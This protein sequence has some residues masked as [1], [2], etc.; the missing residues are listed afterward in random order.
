MGNSRFA[1]MI[2]ACCGFCQP[3]VGQYSK[4]PVR[5]ALERDAGASPQTRADPVTAP[6]VT[7][8]LL[9]A[10]GAPE[11]LPENA[12]VVEADPIVAAVRQQLASMS[13]PAPAQRDDYAALRVFYAARTQ[14]I[15]L[16]QG[17]LTARAQQAILEIGQAENWG[18]Q[19]SAFELPSSVAP[20]SPVEALAE[21]EIKLGVAILKYARQ[22]RGG[23]L[24][25]TTVSR[26][27]DQEPRL[28]DPASLLRAIA[29]VDDIAGYLRGLH[30]RH[31]QFSRLR[32]ALLA[33]RAAPPEPGTATNVRRLI[34]NMERWRWLP[35]D[36]GDF[37]VWDSIPEQMTRVVDRQKVTLSEK[38]VVGKPST[39]TPIFSADMQFIIFHPSWGVPA[40]MKTQELWPQLRNSGGGWFS[41]KPMAS[42]VLAGH[43]LNASRAGQPVNPDAVDWSKVDIREFDFVQPPGP[44][45]VLGIVKFR[46]P[47][48]HDV[49]MH[50]TPER[51]LFNGGVRAFSHGCMR[52]QNP[53]RLAEVL[54]AHDKGW[55]PSEVQGYV[56]RGG[57]I[58]LTTPIPVHVTYFTAI[59]DAAGNVQTFAD[60]YGLDSR[61]TSALEGATV[62]LG[63]GSKTAIAKTPRAAAPSSPRAAKNGKPPQ[64][65][66]PLTAIF[67]N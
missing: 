24:E 14:P 46:F 31:E 43:G 10:P 65:T 8:A 62:S 34:A 64:Q 39:P 1:V 25:P 26:K 61:L 56:R 60:I 17:A 9:P 42:T 29:N 40:G 54:L 58:T 50:D 57:E 53:V 3:A 6:N 66:N 20:I 21:A 35:D 16:A 55:Q 7:G 11:A 18:L 41:G 44:K 36:L 4:A 27:F 38:I 48:R 45:N 2:A 63:S 47:N 67:W 59:V 51:H 13:N 49:Y 23:R 32:Q 15:W 30:P 5:P 52:V 19:A 37:Y 33:A 12:P 28:Y 22:A